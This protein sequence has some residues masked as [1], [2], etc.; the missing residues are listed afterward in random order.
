MNCIKKILELEKY[1]DHDDY[2]YRGIKDIGN[3]FKL[4]I[5]KD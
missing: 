1:N 4:S 5:D 2:K 3:L